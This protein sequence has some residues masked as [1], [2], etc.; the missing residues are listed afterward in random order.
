MVT[1]VGVGALLGARS[2]DLEALVNIFTRVLSDQAIPRPTLAV[3]TLPGV[4]AQVGA[5]AVVSLALIH[6]AFL[7]RLILPVTTVI[8]AVAKIPAVDALV[9]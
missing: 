1:P 3:V 9:E 6:A 7:L 8:P 2:W 4:D 5:A